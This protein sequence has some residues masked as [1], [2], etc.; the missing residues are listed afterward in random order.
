MRFGSIPWRVTR[1][2]LAAS[3]RLAEMADVRRLPCRS[4]SEYPVMAA[5][6]F[7]SFFIRRAMPSSIALAMLVRR[8]LMASK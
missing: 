2:S 5:V 3:A 6:E 1:Y 4:L 8:A 7:R